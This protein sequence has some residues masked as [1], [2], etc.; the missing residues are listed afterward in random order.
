M[1]TADVQNTLDLALQR[2]GVAHVHVRRR[3]RLLS[4]NGPAYL[5][6]ELRRY[7]SSIGIP[8]HE[9]RPITL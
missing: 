5:S 6:S 7:L 2:T 1:R 4:D 8:I 3:P 9:A